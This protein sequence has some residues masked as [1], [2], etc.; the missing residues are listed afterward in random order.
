MMVK[1]RPAAIRVFNAAVLRLLVLKPKEERGGRN[2]IQENEVVH[3]EG[4]VVREQFFK[5][6]S[7]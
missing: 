2:Q 7:P 4:V 6:S 3:M 5:N 1:R